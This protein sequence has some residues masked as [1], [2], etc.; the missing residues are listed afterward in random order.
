MD[1]SSSA[2]RRS[3]TGERGRKGG[4]ER[5]HSVHYRL[6]ANWSPPTI[7]LTS[8]NTPHSHA[9]AFIHLPPV[10]MHLRSFTY[11]RFTCTCVRVKKFHSSTSACQ[12]H[13]QFMEGSILVYLFAK[14]CATIQTSFTLSP[15]FCGKAL[16][17]FIIGNYLH[18][19]RSQ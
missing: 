18:G 17:H 12:R 5:E 4:R 15:T 13:N 2:S 7:L 16:G 10:H 9:P 14:Q 1:N 6:S 8:Q 11:P 3:L 19:E